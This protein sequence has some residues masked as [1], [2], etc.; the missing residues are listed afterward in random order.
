MQIMMTA[1]HLKNYFDKI[2]Y[3]KKPGFLKKM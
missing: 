1:I 2:W 3:T